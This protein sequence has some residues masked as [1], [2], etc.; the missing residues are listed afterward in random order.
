MRWLVAA[1]LWTQIS[2]APLDREV[3]DDELVVLTVCDAIVLFVAEVGGRIAIS[4][5]GAIEG[6]IDW[7]RE[8][9]RFID[10]MHPDHANKIIQLEK[11]YP[12]Y[13]TCP[14]GDEESKRDSGSV[15]RSYVPSGP[16]AL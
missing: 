9:F 10:R 4:T 2:A 12:D 6:S 3:T 5:P 7:A 15:G 1:A 14:D 13:I 8:W 16:R 11:S